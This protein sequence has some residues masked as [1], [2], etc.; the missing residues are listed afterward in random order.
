[1]AQKVTSIDATKTRRRAVRLPE[2]NP[3][4]N[5]EL[6]LREAPP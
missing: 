4:D 5:G 2:E 3:D 6:T 1:M